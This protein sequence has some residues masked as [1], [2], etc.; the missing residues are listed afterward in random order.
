M[1]QQENEQIKYIFKFT[2][3]FQVFNPFFFVGS[4]TNCSED[5][6]TL[7]PKSHLGTHYSFIFPIFTFRREKYR[8]MEQTE[9]RNRYTYPHAGKVYREEGQAYKSKSQIWMACFSLK[10]LSCLS[11][12]SCVFSF[13]FTCRHFSGR[14]YKTL[15]GLQ[16][17]C[18]K[19]AEALAAAAS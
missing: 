12:F 11:R 7:G 18:W 14:F 3:L 10:L 13:T 19:S 16:E 15:V 1:Y 17:S 6:K 9:T 5:K 4:L 8:R 2:L